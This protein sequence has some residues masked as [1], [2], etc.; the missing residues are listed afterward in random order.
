MMDEPMRCFE[1]VGDYDLGGSTV[2]PLGLVVT[3]MR[4]SVVAAVCSCDPFS[5]LPTRGI[6]T[7]QVPAWGVCVGGVPGVV[8]AGFL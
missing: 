4:P 8:C 7:P 2:C 1:G 5:L 6:K 3:T